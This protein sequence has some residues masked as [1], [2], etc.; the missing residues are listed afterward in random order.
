MRTAFVLMALASFSSLAAAQE[1]VLTYTGQ[2]TGSESSILTGATAPTLVP[3]SEAFSGFLN[4][5]GP[6][7]NLTLDGSAG[8]AADTAAPYFPNGPDSFF[9]S[10]PHSGLASTIDIVT[11][12]AS[13]L[14]ADVDIN[15][16]PMSMITLSANGAA[17][18]F[19]VLGSNVLGDCESQLGAIT[20][21][22]PG[23]VANPGPAIPCSFNAST[24]TGTWTVTSTAAPEIDPASGFSALTLLLGAVAV[25]RGRRGELARPTRLRIRTH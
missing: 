21:S 2:L 9:S 10:V 18:D 20:H 6:V 16:G 5:N 25:I 17:S 1:Y 11:Q 12:G 23:T 8:L 24:T 3:F 14:G 15:N 22:A 19:E 13:I 7:G 4:L